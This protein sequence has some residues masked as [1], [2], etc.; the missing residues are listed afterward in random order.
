[1]KGRLGWPVR[2]QTLYNNDSEDID[3]GIS[4]LGVWIVD[5]VGFQISAVIFTLCTC[6]GSD[7]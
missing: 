4:F 7:I 6:S 3:R 5:F 2:V 1:M